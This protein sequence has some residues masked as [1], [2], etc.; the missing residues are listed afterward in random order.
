MAVLMKFHSDEKSILFNSVKLKSK[1]EE[2]RIIP[3]VYWFNINQFQSTII[4]IPIEL[5][6]DEPVLEFE[7]TPKTNSIVTLFRN[8][9]TSTNSLEYLGKYPKDM[10]C[11]II[12]NTSSEFY[13][14]VDIF[15]IPK[16]NTFIKVKSPLCSYEDVQESVNEKSIVFKNLK[17][18]SKNSTQMCMPI[19]MRNLIDKSVKENHVVNYF[20]AMQFQSSVIDV[21]N[22]EL[23]IDK[24]H[25]YTFDIHPYSKVMLF[26]Y[27]D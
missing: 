25:A 27:N 10:V 22:I 1:K 26:F 2:E 14:G 19:Y 3:L 24:D 9:F 8:D 15:N 6:L 20:S 7:V 16:S 5:T 12:E 11:L 21:D 13:K 17:I 23:P 4:N 18:V